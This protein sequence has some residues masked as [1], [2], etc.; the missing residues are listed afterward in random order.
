MDWI[1]RSEA[2]TEAIAAVVRRQFP[3]VIITEPEAGLFGWQR[4]ANRIQMLVNDPGGT[5]RLAFVPQ[6]PDAR[7]QTFPYSDRSV[8]A[9]AA[10]IIEWLD[11]R[12]YRT[13]GL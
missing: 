12:R 10:S 9:V 7:P 13:R 5:V 2:F 11:Y 1:E 8:S 3:D 6:S 4:G